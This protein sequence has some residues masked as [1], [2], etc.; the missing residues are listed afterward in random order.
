MAIK[1][2]VFNGGSASRE[3]GEKVICFEGQR[4]SKGFFY[5]F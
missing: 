3:V 2:L 1:P 4:R 5:H